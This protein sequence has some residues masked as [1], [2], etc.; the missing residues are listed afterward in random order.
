MLL[1]CSRKGGEHR[2]RQVSRGKRCQISLSLSLMEPLGLW[3]LRI[4]LF[5]KQQFFRLSADNKQNIQI[6]LGVSQGRVI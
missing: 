6:K 3:Y 5:A 2:H 4:S 1:I